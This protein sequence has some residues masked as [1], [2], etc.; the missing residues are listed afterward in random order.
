MFKT[1][2]G[3]RVDVAYKNMMSKLEREA[4][5]SEKPSDVVGR[6]IMIDARDARRSPEAVAYSSF[7]HH[8]E[9]TTPQTVSRIQGGFRPLEAPSHQAFSKH[10]R[11][12]VTLQPTIA[13]TAISK[14][15]WHKAALDR[16]I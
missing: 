3:D 9:H 2:Y 15:C 6:S 5:P 10:D 14:R 8:S 1:Q 16:C 12:F 11:G 13:E 4:A 7:G